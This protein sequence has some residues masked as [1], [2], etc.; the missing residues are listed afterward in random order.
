MTETTLSR[1]YYLSM[2]AP[3]LSL[4]EQIGMKKIIAHAQALGVK[5]PIKNEIGSAIGGSDLTFYDLARS[6]LPYATNGVKKEIFSIVDISDRNGH[7]LYKQKPASHEQ[8]LDP[9]VAALT[10]NGMR[11]VLSRGT[12]A[13]HGQLAGQGVYGKTG[14]SNKNKDNWFL[15]FN[16]KVMTIVWVGTDSPQGIPGKLGGG[17]LALPI[18]SQFMSTA[19]QHYPSTAIAKPEGIVHATVDPYTGKL[20]ENGIE[21]AFKLGSEPED[22]NDV[23]TLRWVKGVG[24]GNYRELYELE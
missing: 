4:A 19:L 10:R 9:I 23:S 20:D 17:K 11:H 22:S 12:G 21:M 5:T 14:T 2:N 8:V 6:Y 15:G 16:D 3:L 13:T 7:S 18:F 24:K 1:A